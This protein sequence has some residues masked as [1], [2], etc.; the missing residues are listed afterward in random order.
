MP[1]YIY[2][3]LGILIMIISF[4]LLRIF[5][6]KLPLWMYAIVAFTPP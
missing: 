6:P 2:V 4:T 1:K 5:F 3:L